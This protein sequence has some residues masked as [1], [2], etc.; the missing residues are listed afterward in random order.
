MV[1]YRSVSPDKGKYI[2]AEGHDMLLHLD[3]DMGKNQGQICR[4]RTARWPGTSWIALVLAV[5]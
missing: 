4:S 3:S 5:L 2:Q 1:V